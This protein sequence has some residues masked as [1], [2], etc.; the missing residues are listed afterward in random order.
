MMAILGYSGLHSL[1]PRT[2][3]S[4]ALAPIIIH[5]FVISVGMFNWQTVILC[6]SAHIIVEAYDQLA[7]C[8]I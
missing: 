8:G 7:E 4:S 2:P 3:L 6:V 1:L 5:P